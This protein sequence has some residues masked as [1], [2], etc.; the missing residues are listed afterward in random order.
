MAEDTKAP[1]A[2]PM[3]TPAKP[4]TTKKAAAAKRLAKA[5]GANGDIT[6]PAAK[7]RPAV[8]KT[9]AKKKSAKKGTDTE[10]GAPVT[11]S[12]GAK[13]E[14]ELSQIRDL[15]DEIDEHSWVLSA[16]CYEITSDS[17]L[18]SDPAN[19]LSQAQLAAEIGVS[20]ATMSAWVHTHRIFGDP[21]DRH[22]R[23]FG[24]HL[25][26]ARQMTSDGSKKDA[27]EW[28]EV[29]R[30]L[31]EDP[32]VNSWAVALRKVRKAKVDAAKAKA[33]TPTDVA[34]KIVETFARFGDEFRSKAGRKAQ[35]QAVAAILDG[36]VSDWGSVYNKAPDAALLS[37]IDE[38]V[39]RAAEL[40]RIAH[41]LA[42]E[43]RL[44]KAAATKKADD[45]AKAAIEGAK[46]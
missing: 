33:E 31:A 9:P 16:M 43:D 38:I 42:D 12:P 32:D 39:E 18:E 7:K 8:K 40:G 24:D 20:P 36:A 14:A 41:R 1:P 5:A 13:L 25:E 3:A 2:D 34:D 44:R 26:M 21:K 19:H 23:S 37:T 11:A 46:A 35:T 22:D 17:R 29:E 28:D 27:D 6:P 10:A 4:V 15:S 45:A 30:F